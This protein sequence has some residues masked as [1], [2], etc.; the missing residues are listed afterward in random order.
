MYLRYPLADLAGSASKHSSILIDLYQASSVD[1]L[2]EYEQLSQVLDLKHSRT[3]LVQL[4]HVVGT[5]VIEPW[6]VS[7]FGSYFVP[8]WPSLSIGQNTVC[9]DSVIDSFSNGRNTA[10]SL[11]HYAKCAAMTAVP[12]PVFPKKN[13][14]P[15]FF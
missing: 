9:P 1:R 3:T 14:S 13:T 15:S 4:R 5:E 11:N 12:A 6:G 7:I 2:T 8:H 10:A